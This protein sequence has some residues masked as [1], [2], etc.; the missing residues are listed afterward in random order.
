MPWALTKLYRTQIEKSIKFKKEKL[1][2]EKINYF[3]TRGSDEKSLRK[4]RINSD[5]TFQ[6]PIILQ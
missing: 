6:F 5:V 1:E 4:T 2:N 3:N